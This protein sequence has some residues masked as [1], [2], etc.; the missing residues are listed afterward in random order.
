ME[1]QHLERV[2][3]E[4]YDFRFGDYINEGF[5]IFGK[6]V[7]GFVG[8]TLIYLAIA[9]VAQII[10]FIGPLASMVITP[11]L[12]VGFAI[13]AHKVHNEERFEFNHFFEGFQH[14]GPLFLTSLVGGLII[15]LTCLPLLM[16]AGAM[17]FFSYD[18]MLNSAVDPNVSTMLLFSFLGL[19]FLI[20]AIYLGVAY[21]WASMFVIFYK[22]EFWDALETS[23]KLISKNWFMVFLF[24]FVVGII[25]VLGVLGFCIGLFFTMPAAYCM[26]YAAFADVTRLNQM[27]DDMDITDH[28]IDDTYL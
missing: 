15:V 4:D 7:G 18:S 27:G 11:A 28:L 5:S 16:A 3:N 9:S 25:A 6:N 12:V 22:L 23:R 1:K 8:Y 24:A 26:Q 21:S 13:V 20:P 17:A 2:L 14:L 19:L 10:P